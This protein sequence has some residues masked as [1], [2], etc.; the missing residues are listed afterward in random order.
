MIDMSWQDSIRKEKFQGPKREG[1]DFT[2]SKFDLGLGFKQIN[3]NID[4]I[5]ETVERAMDA[6]AQV[7]KSMLK[8]IRRYA[9][10]AKRAID[11]VD[12]KMLES[13]KYS[14]RRDSDYVHI[15]GAKYR[16]RDGSLTFGGD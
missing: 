14:K 4:N 2:P 16:N 7:V 8:S 11:E 1:A 13:A 10:E 15:E 3:Y 9:E 6:D 5:M 12:E